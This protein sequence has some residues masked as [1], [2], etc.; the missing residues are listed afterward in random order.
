MIFFSRE[1]NLGM[2]IGET[3]LNSFPLFLIA[4]VEIGSD[5]KDGGGGRGV[6]LMENFEASEKPCNLNG[7]NSR[8][9]K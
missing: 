4:T 5:S 6:V 7:S 9:L 1:A 3:I 8:S 2:F